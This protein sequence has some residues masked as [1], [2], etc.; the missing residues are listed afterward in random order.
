MKGL[1]LFQT[2]CYSMSHLRH[3]HTPSFIRNKF[4]MPY[5]PFLIYAILRL[6]KG[7]LDDSIR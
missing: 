3:H 7:E 2:I 1:N 5:Y 6:Y 4:I